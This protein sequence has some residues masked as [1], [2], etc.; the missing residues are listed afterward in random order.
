MTAT[1]IIRQIKTLPTAEQA[2]VRDW[3]QRCEFEEPP[4]M[5]AALDRAAQS[6]D[7]RGTTPVADVRKQLPAWISKSA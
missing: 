5:L 7:Q 2:K 6:A 1:D 4:E 3:M